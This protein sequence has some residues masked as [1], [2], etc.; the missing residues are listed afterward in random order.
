MSKERTYSEPEVIA[1]IERAIEHQAIRTTD[2]AKHG[3]TISEIEQLG[4][5][6]GIAP[7]LLRKAAKEVGSGNHL[8]TRD[9]DE[10][11]S[12]I[13]V[14]RWIP[15]RLPEGAIEDM[16]GEMQNHLGPESGLTWSGRFWAGSP[17]LTGSRVERVGRTFSWAHSAARIS[18]TDEGDGYTLR[19][20]TTELFSGK[21]SEGIGAAAWVGLALGGLIGGGVG[22]VYGGWWAV[23]IVSLALVI[24]L[25]TVPRLTRLKRKRSV[26]R[27][28]SLAGEAE[29][30]LLLAAESPAQ[31]LE[32]QAPLLSLLDVGLVS[33][34]AG[35]SGT[36]RRA[37][38]G[39]G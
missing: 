30:L 11:A 38:E 19:V 31:G 10:R 34:R 12:Q 24:S 33:D 20:F 37:A 4:R 36:V 3:L 28:E 15:G 18:V 14:E 16:F 17:H 13:R 26:E 22:E 21:T 6:A 29:Q 2:T 9:I 39:F 35:F 1:I 5:E 7:E 23:M 32:Q 27:L 8:S 25:V